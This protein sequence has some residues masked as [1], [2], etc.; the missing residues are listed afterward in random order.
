MMC[1]LSNFSV[2]NAFQ[3]SLF[4]NSFS[5]L[6]IQHFFTYWRYFTGSAYFELYYFFGRYPAK[7]YEEIVRSDNFHSIAATID[8]TI[9]AFIVCQV[10]PISACNVE[11]A[12]KKSFFFKQFNFNHQQTIAFFRLKSQNPRD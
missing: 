5:F 4:L 3:F 9:V 12:I 1:L 6:K 7:W 8:H 2:T 10:K 11:V